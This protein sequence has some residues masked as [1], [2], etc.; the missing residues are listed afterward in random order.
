MEGRGGGRAGGGRSW[1]RGSG[2]FGVGSNRSER[3]GE[4]SGGRGIRRPRAVEDSRPPPLPSRG[5]SQGP[6]GPHGPSIPPS[7]LGRGGGEKGPPPRPSGLSG[8]RTGFNPS[9]Q[10]EG[11]GLGWGREP[12]PVRTGKGHVRKV[13]ST[14]E[15]DEH[16]H[17]FATRKRRPPR[18]YGRRERSRRREGKWR[19]GEFLVWMER[20]QRDPRIQ[21]G[22]RLA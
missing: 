11:M 12:G 20:G 4:G 3:G 2:G 18:A 6:H 16:G 10:R 22:K 21:R 5:P 15:P 7:P 13:A 14:L 8:N 19:D 17:P 9:I 1:R